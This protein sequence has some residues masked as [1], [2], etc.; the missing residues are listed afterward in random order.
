M[1]SDNIFLDREIGNYDQNG[2]FQTEEEA[3]SLDEKMWTELTDRYS[4]EYCFRISVMDKKG[5]LN[6]VLEMCEK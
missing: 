2:R 4:E 3:K 6:K 1:L 5:I